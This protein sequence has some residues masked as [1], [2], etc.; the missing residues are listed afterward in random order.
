MTVWSQPS[1]CAIVIIDNTVLPVYRL[2]Y[3]NTRMP[4]P[5]GLGKTKRYEV[6]SKN[7]YIVCVHLLDSVL[8]ECTLNAESTGQECLENISTR[9]GLNEVIGVF[10]NI[11]KKICEFGS[12]SHSYISLSCGQKTWILMKIWWFLMKIWYLGIFI[13]DDYVKITVFRCSILDCVSSTR[14]HLS[15]G[16]S[17]LTSHWRSSLKNMLSHHCFTLESCSVLAMSF[18][19]K[20]KCQGQSATTFSFCNIFAT[21]FSWHFWGYC[22]IDVY[23]VKFLDITRLH[24]FPLFA[25]QLQHSFYRFYHFQLLVSVACQSWDLKFDSPMW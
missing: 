24:Q 4:F 7:S 6:S 9:I 3:K 10:N 21:L 16:G 11:L 1:F 20:M 8:I 23:K 5:F 17:T 25:V 2:F 19:S 12:H 22:F 13:G 14:G 18:R 15:F